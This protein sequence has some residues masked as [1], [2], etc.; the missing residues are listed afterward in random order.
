MTKKVVFQWNQ[1][2]GR[3]SHVSSQLLHP[4]GTDVWAPNTDV[5]EGPDNIII[6]M[7]LPGVTQQQ[8]DIYLEQH[9]LIVRGSRKDPACEES[10]AGYRFRQLEIEYGAFQRVIEIPYPVNGAKARAVLRN[11][12]LELSL[13][14]AREDR[15]KHIH[16]EV[17]S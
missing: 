17:E 4:S 7:E 8:M 14:R 12:I 13:P 5:S 1:L 16:V 9:K 15:Q 2:R 3:S 11:G 6:R 10:A